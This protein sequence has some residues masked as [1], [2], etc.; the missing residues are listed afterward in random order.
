MQKLTLLSCILA[1]FVIPILVGR[2]RHPRRGLK[3]VFIL[4]VMFNLWYWFVIRYLY[5]HL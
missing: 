4:M 2:G 5:R 3:K 1:I